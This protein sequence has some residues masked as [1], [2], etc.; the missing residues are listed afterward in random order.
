KIAAAKYG[1][2]TFGIGANFLAVPKNSNLYFNTHFSYSNYKIGLDEADGRT[3]QS[4]IGGFDI[5]MDFNY[6]IRQGD[7][8]YG[9]DVQ[10]NK[11]NFAFV[12]SFGQTVTQ[13]Q[14]TTDL[15]AYVTVHKFYKKFVAEGGFRFQY[16]GNLGAISPEPRLSMKYNAT[17]W[18]RF[19]MASGLYS[20]N[21]ISTVSN[22]DVVDLFT[23][24]LTGSNSTPANAPKDSLK[25]HNMQRGV[26]AIFG[27]EMD[28]PKNISINIEPYYKYFW[29]L[30]DINQY[31]VYNTDPD[32]MNEKGDAYGLDF[33]FKWQYKGAFLYAT[34]SLSWVHRNDGE[35]VYYPYYDRRHNVN[36]VAAYTFGKKHDWEASGRWN[37]GSGFPFTQTQGFYEFNPFSNGIA[38]NYTTTNGTLGVVYSSTID[39]G[40]LPLYHRLDLQIKKVF[41]LKK[42]MKVDIA[43]SVSNVYNRD[44]I[45][46]FDRIHYV[47]VNQLPVIPSLAASF[48][49]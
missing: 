37:L 16:Y 45:F 14:N 34:Y 32:F 8:K 35:Q 42:R 36:V 9:L 29:H 28:L 38:T 44:N 24:F 2:S 3:R 25:S 27:I 40:R 23:G 12:N 10:G 48:S 41:N 43:A 5:G 4:S 1:W 47:R 49:W 30:L 11:T 33:L 19:K 13:D 26:D 18:L 46:Y 6:Y 39:G 31:K 22:Q 20:Q 21:I 7:L 15:S 17:N